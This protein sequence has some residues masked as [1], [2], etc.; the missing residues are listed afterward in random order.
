MYKVGYM[1]EYAPNGSDIPIGDVLASEGIA[2][3]PAGIDVGP[4][5]DVA[6]RA[7]PLL[8]GALGAAIGWYMRPRRFQVGR[9]VAGSLLGV[10]AGYTLLK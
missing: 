4:V 1:P 6:R 5:P 3:P 10:A 9:A 7:S 8:L 2:V